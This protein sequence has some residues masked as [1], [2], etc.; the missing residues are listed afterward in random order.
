MATFDEIQAEMQKRGLS[1]DAAA[2]AP[3]PDPHAETANHFQGIQDHIAQLHNEAYGGPKNS[4]GAAI[5][6]GIVDLWDGVP[7]TI[8][9]ITK[10]PSNAVTAASQNIAAGTRQFQLQGGLSFRQISD[11]LGL[12]NPDETKRIAQLAKN[13]AAQSAQSASDLGQ[14]NVGVIGQVLGQA[15]PTLAT[16]GAPVFQAVKGA[17]FA[18]AAASAAGGA[19]AQALQY[20]PQGLVEKTKNIGKTAAV[21]AALTAIPGMIGSSYNRNVKYLQD[22]WGS[23]SWDAK[24]MEAFKL[25]GVQP[26]AWQ[27]TNNSQNQM[28]YANIGAYLNKQPFVGIAGDLSRQNEHAI[29]YMQKIFT[30]MDG[31]KA[32]TQQTYHNAYEAVKAKAPASY[33]DLSKVNQAGEQGFNSLLKESRGVI[34]N[35][36]VMNVLDE[37]KAAGPM[38]IEDMMKL[39]RNLDTAIKENTFTGPGMSPLTYSENQILKPIRGQLNEAI[40]T[41]A[42]NIGVGAEFAQGNLAYRD[43]LWLDNMRDIWSRGFSSAPKGGGGSAPVDLELWENANSKFVLGKFNKALSRGT[44]M[45]EAQGLKPSINYT[46]SNGATMNYN[47]VIKASKVL[48]QALEQQ[49]V[50]PKGPGLPVDLGVLGEPLK[51]AGKAIAFLPNLAFTKGLTYL[52]QDP[53]GLALLTK[54]GKLVDKLP[55]TSDATLKVYK[56]RVGRLVLTA[57]AAV[58]AVDQVKNPRMS[59]SPIA[60]GLLASPDDIRAEMEKRG[61]PIP[62]ATPIPTPPQQ[63]Q[64]NQ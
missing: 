5:M 51:L 46:F 52:M 31:F 30:N 7:S 10:N 19:A 55:T 16:A 33:F 56:S 40:K 27:I 4:T 28:T 11:S 8:E 15:V 63:P 50:K 2:A 42:N 22:A 49:T 14:P 1:P 54:F 35:P 59:V 24:K 41:H 34:K 47:D 20:E 17:G 58:T 64:G 21:S 25:A 60:S 38:N 36:G 29:D 12:T 6:K 37:I 62:P 32:S 39:Q 43:N 53:D 26:Y 13:D 61:L 57:M 23:P 44:T 45:L 9:Q 18:P 48:G 3:T